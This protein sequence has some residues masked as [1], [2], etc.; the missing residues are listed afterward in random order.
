MA[1]KRPEWLGWAAL[2]I[3]VVGLVSVVIWSLP[4]GGTPPPAEDAGAAEADASPAEPPRASRGETLDRPP[5]AS[6]EIALVLEDRADLPERTERATVARMLDARHCGSACDAVKKLVLDEQH[7]ELE[8]MTTEELVLPAKDTWDTV[9]ASLTSEERASLDK[10]T[11]A[12]VI[13]THGPGA[14]DHLPVRT[15]LAVASA[16]AES[17]SALVYD[18]TLRRIEAPRDLAKRLITA[19]LGQPVLT[20][21]H[22]VVQLYRQDDAT[23]RMLTLGMIRFGSPDLALR[24]ATMADAPRLGLVLDAAAAKVAAGESRLPLTVT[25]DDVAKVAGVAPSALASDP[26]KS[27]PA[28][29]EAFEPPRTEGDPDNELAELLPREGPTPETWAAVLTGL[30][31]RAPQVAFT[32][33]DAE[34]Q[35]IAARA[36]RELPTA[37]AQT[38]K[39]A[40]LFVK[41][42]FSA[43]DAGSEWMWIEA[44]RCDAK[45]CTGPLTNTPAFA[46]NFAEGKPATVKR[47]EIADWLLRL[48]DGGTQGGASIDVLERR[49]VETR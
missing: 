28:V 23:A 3:L 48:P 8:R 40:S 27:V 5:E 13:R 19:P 10:R 24:G 32:A 47:A 1:S 2:A 18:E 49:S 44:K 14:P 6:C 45:T 39:G 16:L 15:C 12:V 11:Q 21:R 7:A 22:L 29:L 31:Q 34:L 26:A 42:P 33:F 20:Q 43:G 25:L 41:A 46:T 35:T 30:L 9:A 37:I 4:K 36:R 38:T 17:L